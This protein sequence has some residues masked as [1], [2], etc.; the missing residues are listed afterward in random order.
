[1]EFSLNFRVWTQITKFKEDNILSTLHSL[2]VMYRLTKNYIYLK[3]KNL[4]QW[5]NLNFAKHSCLKK[6]PP[7]NN[8]FG[9]SKPE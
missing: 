2:F 3:I 8:Y 1:M 5:N 6:K 4:K 9:Y 7:L